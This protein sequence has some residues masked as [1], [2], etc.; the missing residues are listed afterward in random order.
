LVLRVG[1][2]LLLHESRRERF[3]LS[4]RALRPAREFLISFD[5]NALFPLAIVTKK[6]YNS[7]DVGDAGIEVYKPLLKAS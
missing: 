1:L 4:L 6:T 5:E 7:N 2:R 3:C